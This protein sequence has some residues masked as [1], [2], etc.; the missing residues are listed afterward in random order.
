M[1]IFIVQAI[2]IVWFTDF[3]HSIFTLF[4]LQPLKHSFTLKKGFIFAD[5]KI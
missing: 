2:D 3:L 4:L 1:D 5:L